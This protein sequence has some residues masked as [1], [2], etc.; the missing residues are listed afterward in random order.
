LICRDRSRLQVALAPDSNGKAKLPDSEN[1][2]SEGRATEADRHFRHRRRSPSP[3]TLY[4]KPAR[5]A[6]VS[7]TRAPVPVSRRGG[8]CPTS[9]KRRPRLRNCRRDAGAG[10]SRKQM[11]VVARMTIKGPQEM[12]VRA[13]HG[14][15]ADLASRRHP[16]SCA[17]PRAGLCGL[18]GSGSRAQT[19]VGHK[20]DVHVDF[21]TC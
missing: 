2:D 10:R 5:Y 13:R 15:L 21:A 12:T 19:H 17:G 6:C 7:A 9:R 4:R 11:T 3:R 14:L 1:G 18:S 8:L 16:V 20:I